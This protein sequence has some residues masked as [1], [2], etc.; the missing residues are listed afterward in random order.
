MDGITITDYD[1]KSFKIGTDSP[2]LTE[3]EKEECLFTIEE[4]IQYAE[5]FKERLN[6]LTEDDFNALIDVSSALEHLERGFYYV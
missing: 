2:V 5:T 3:E 4:I 1:V 6:E